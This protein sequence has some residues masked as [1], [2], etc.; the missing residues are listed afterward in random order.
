MCITVSTCNG[1][2]VDQWYEGLVNIGVHS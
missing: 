2:S 1:S